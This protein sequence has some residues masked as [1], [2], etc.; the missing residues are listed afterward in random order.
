MVPRIYSK[1]VWSFRR[2]AQPMAR[3]LAPPPAHVLDVGAAPFVV[4]EALTNCGYHVTALDLAPERFE[5]IDRLACKVIA[6]D[7]EKSAQCNVGG[8]FDAVVLSHVIEHL[9]FDLLDTLQFIRGVL[10]NDGLLIL[11]TPNLLSILGWYNLMT[12]RTAYSCAGSVYHEWSKISRLGHMGHVR[13]YTDNE[14]YELLVKSGF[15][16][17]AIGHIDFVQRN[18]IK[19]LV[20]HLLQSLFPRLRLNISLIVR[21]DKN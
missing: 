16:V 17:E 18:T 1:P 8:P 3:H 6:G 10:T 2:S 5:N 21:K 9:R 20:A 15:R 19:K 13:E 11:E 12:K 14:L 7:A 4:A